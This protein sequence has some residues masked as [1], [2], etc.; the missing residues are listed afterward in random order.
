MDI[1]YTLINYILTDGD[2]SF[3]EDHISKLNS[4][5]PNSTIDIKI[6]EEKRKLY[7]IDIQV[8]LDHVTIRVSKKDSKFYDILEKSIDSLKENIIRYKD[9]TRKYFEG[10]SPWQDFENTDEKPFVEYRPV[11]KVKKYEDDTPMHPQEAIERMTLLGHK[12]FIFKNI[13]NDKYAMVY[14]RDDGFTF[15]LVEPA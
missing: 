12:S 15:G 6:T 4:I 1:K 14:I 2:K 9:K 11:I 13:E 10:E 5:I 3:I 8:K 7:K